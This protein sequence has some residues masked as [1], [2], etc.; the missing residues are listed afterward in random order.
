MS[1]PASAMLSHLVVVFLHLNK[2]NDVSILPFSVVSVI[3]K[4][5]FSYGI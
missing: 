1:V 5:V 4:D 2:D 3:M